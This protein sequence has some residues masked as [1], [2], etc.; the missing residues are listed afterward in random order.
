MTLTS[1][2]TSD[3]DHNRT[4]QTARKRLRL[5]RARRDMCLY[6]LDV[7]TSFTSAF[8]KHLTLHRQGLIT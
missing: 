6:L 2:V 4:L 5:Q 7:F 1:E 8:R 3:R